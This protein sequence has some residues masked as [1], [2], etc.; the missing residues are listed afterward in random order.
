MRR[1]RT[2]VVLGLAASLAL[3]A[4]GCG[5]A[6]NGGDGEGTIEIGGEQANDHG[7]SD[8]SGETSIEFEL[9]D[10]YF[11]PTILEGEAGQTLTLEAFNEGDSP[12]TFTIDGTDVDEELQAGDRAEIEVTF[13]ESGALVFHCHFHDGQG[14]RGALSVGGSLEVTSGGGGEDDAN[15]GEADQEDDD[16]GKY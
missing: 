9:D 4:A 6:G 3:V 13:P 15:H 16:E 2:A 5:G 1:T 14:M 7:R 11:E 10:N 12:H 8:V